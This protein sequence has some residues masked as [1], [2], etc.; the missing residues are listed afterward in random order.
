MLSS[1]DEGAADVDRARTNGAMDLRR[2]RPRADRA[3]RDRAGRPA[4]TSQRHRRGGLSTSAP[5]TSTRGLR[6]RRQVRSASWAGRART[7]GPHGR[8]QFTLVGA[9]HRLVPRLRHA[10]PAGRLRRPVRSTSARPRRASTARSRWR[11]ASAA[12]LGTP[13]TLSATVTENG[14]PVAERTVTFTVIDGPNAGLD[15]DRGRP[16]EDGLATRRATTSAA[17]GTDVI[18]AGYRRRPS[19]AELRSKPLERD[20]DPRRRLPA[21]AASCVAAPKDTDK[22]GVPDASD[23]CP[24]VANA[25]QKD[26]DGDKVGDACDILP[27]GDAPVVAGATAQVTAVSGEVFIKLPEGDE[28]PGAGGEGLRAGRAEGADQR[29][30]P[31]QGRRDRADRLARSTRA[32]ASSSS[33]PRRSSGPRASGPN[34][35]QGRFGAGDV[36]DPPGRA[37]GARRRGS[38]QAEPPTWCCRRRPGMSRAC[39]AGSERAADQGHRAHADGDRQGRVPHD[40]RRGHDHRH[41]RHLDRLGPLRRHDDRGRPRQGR[42]PR[43]A[44]EEGLHACAPARA[45]WRRAKLFAAKTKQEA[46]PLGGDRGGLGRRADGLA[47]LEVEA[48]QAGG[49][50]GELDPVADRDRRRG[51]R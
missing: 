42:R 30:R 25:D 6:L 32:R 37:S 17:E 7:T 36:R 31:D 48:V 9:R 46:G 27:P 8:S 11:G 39:A 28:G 33:R 15:A 51:R 26:A 4:A 34:L 50:D 10:R 40:R 23:N 43:H 38:S 45:T 20:L 24:E 18:E 21:A 1:I 41:R 19:S 16:D 2:A 29:L 5:A 44:A 3:A 35:Q 49:V 14:A 13:Q 22:D 47:G 12:T